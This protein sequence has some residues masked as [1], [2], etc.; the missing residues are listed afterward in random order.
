M[1]NNPNSRQFGSRRAR[2]RQQS[3]INRCA[4]TMLKAI[5]KEA[6]LPECL[7]EPIKQLQV[8]QASFNKVFGKVKP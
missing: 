3:E 4:R 2:N 5:E 6:Q 7:Q 1:A 8:M